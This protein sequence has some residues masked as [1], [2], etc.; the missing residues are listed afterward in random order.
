MVLLND[1]ALRSG[2]GTT[3]A[4]GATSIQSCRWWRWAISRQTW[5]GCVRGCRRC[6][7]HFARG[8]RD[9]DARR[10]DRGPARSPGRPRG[11]ADPSGGAFPP[12]GP[13][14]AVAGVGR[15][16][17]RR[18]VESARRGVAVDAPGRG[19]PGG[20]RR[21]A[22]GGLDR[23]GIGEVAGLPD[24]GT[25]L[26]GD[27]PPR[28]R[29]ARLDR[30][31]PLPHQGP[32]AGPARGL[33]AL[34]VPDLRATT[35]DGDSSREQRD[36]ARDHGEY[37]LTN[38]DML[39]RSMLPAHARWSRFFAMLDYVV[40]DECHH[41]RGVFGAHVAQIMR[42]LRRVCA[43]YGSHPTFVV[44]SATVAEPEV[45]AGRL[46]GLPFVAVTED[47]SPRR[48]GA[49]AVGA[50]VRL[51]RR[52]ERRAGTTLRDRGDRRPAHRPR[53]RERPHPGLHPLA[54]GHGDRLDDHPPPPRRGEPGAVVAGGRLPRWL[55]ARG[56]PGDRAGA[57]AGGAA[58]PGRHQ[59]PRARHRHRRPR[60]GA[61]GRLPRHPCG[62]VAA[63]RP[64]RA[65]RPGRARRLRRARRPAR[66]LPREPPG[67]ADRPARRGQR[68][69]PRQPLRAGP[70]PVRRGRGVPAHRGGPAAVRLRARR[71]VDALTEA[72][73]LRRRAGLVLDRPAPRQRPGRHPLHRRRRCGWWSRT[74][75]GSSAPWTSPPRTAP[76][77]PARCTS[78]RA[79]PTWCCRSTSPTT[80]RW[81]SR[82]AVVLHLGPR[83][84][85]HRHHRRA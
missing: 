15:P 51:A 14:Y 69:R 40:V 21:A 66:H 77:T 56:P 48:G 35:H 45:A 83:A 7:R 29:P 54:P 58:G 11:P 84:D 67:G 24:A 49:R 46:T 68:L 22:R 65:R 12:Y 74:P 80:S 50:A 4:L 18:G 76:R 32:G 27:R 52:G 59:R 73:L 3:G 37:L 63:D 10:G 30:P 38:P 85:R 79:R 75:A 42:R 62:A 82:G 28:E 39:H 60:R 26:G 41:Y 33:L 8:P 1:A 20:V 9:V 43:L 47:G 44:A 19:R 61:D 53:A 6:L 34:G 17:A 5:P 72:G 13:P 36:W 70:A 23:Y 81:W 31:L 55:P 2:E 25:H 57:P 16:G 71:G 78:T 64:C